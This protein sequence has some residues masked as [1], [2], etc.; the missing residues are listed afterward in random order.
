VDAPGAVLV[1]DTSLTVT[2]GFTLEA[3]TVVFAGGTLSVGTFEQD[4][5]LITGSTVDIVS[6]GTISLDGGEIDAGV[7]ALTSESSLSPYGS[8]YNMGTIL[9]EGDPGSTFTVGD[10]TA[11]TNEDL[12]QVGNGEDLV[13]QASTFDNTGTLAF[14]GAGT[15]EFAGSISNLGTIQFSPGAAELLILDDPATLT[16]SGIENFGIGDAIEFGGSLDVY[17]A[18]FM[19]PGTITAITSDGT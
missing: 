11:L 9:A 6:T 1:L 12:I 3:G 13:I 8:L 17:S 5:G 14:T 2:D 10:L 16:T 4:G 19:A 15:I 18:S 7:V